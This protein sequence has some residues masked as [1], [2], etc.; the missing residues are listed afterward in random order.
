MLTEALRLLSRL[1]WAEVRESHRSEPAAVSVGADVEL[2]R[3]GQVG[4][5]LLCFS[6]KPLRTRMWTRLFLVNIDPGEADRSAGWNSAVYDQPAGNRLSQTASL[7]MDVEECS[8]KK[9]LSKSKNEKINVSKY[10]GKTLM[11][12]Q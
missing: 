2:N 4:S 11:Q 7:Q 12:F 9:R 6:S 1:Q 3:F 5:D 8:D 10:K